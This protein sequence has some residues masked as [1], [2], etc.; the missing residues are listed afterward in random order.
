MR[1]RGTG[2][3]SIEKQVLHEFD[4][5]GRGAEEEEKEKAE[6]DCERESGFPAGPD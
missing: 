5:K 3:R 2:W 1:V 6:E 4:R